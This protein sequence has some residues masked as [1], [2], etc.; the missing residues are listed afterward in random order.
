MFA[1]MTCFLATFGVPTLPRQTTISR[2]D[3]QR[4]DFGADSTGTCVHGM[5]RIYIGIM[6][7]RFHA[8][9]T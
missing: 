5:A 4:S 7:D 3:F 8:V 6:P 1:V 9:G 2:H